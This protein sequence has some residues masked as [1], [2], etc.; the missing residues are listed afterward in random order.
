MVPELL[1]PLFTFCFSAAVTPGPNNIMLTASG[2]TFGFKR[3]IPHLL[4]IS[5]GFPAMVLAIGLGLGAIFEQFPVLHEVLKLVGAAY[6]LYLAWRVAT[7]ERPSEGR[8]GGKPLTFLQAAAF[9]W[10]NPKA[11]VIGVGAVAAFSSLELSPLANTLMIAGAFFAA[12]FPSTALW[13]AFGTAI[14][15]LLSS[16]R[17]L[18][19]F[20]LSLG[21][22]TALSV[23]LIFV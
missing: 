17:A 1:A 21:A 14:G 23:V 5:L 11:W 22:V 9:Q 12:T 10:V 20:N 6:L 3:T 4:G 13:A 8:T 7:N 19:T 2:A 15:R 16:R 18:R